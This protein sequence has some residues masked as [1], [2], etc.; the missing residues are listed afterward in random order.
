MKHQKK[1]SNHLTPIILVL[2]VVVV[3]L[4]AVLA[5]L[6]LR[7]G[8]EATV[9]ES[10][11]LPQLDVIPG[12]LTPEDAPLQEAPWEVPVDVPVEPEVE[13]VA[14]ETPYTTLYFPGEW[15]KVLLVEHLDGEVYTVKFSADL[16]SGLVVPLFEIRLGGAI[17]DGFACIMTPEGEMMAV[18]AE[19]YEFVPSDGMRDSEIII[20]YSMQEA[21]NDVLDRMNLIYTDVTGSEPVDN[22]EGQSGNGGTGSNANGAPGNMLPEDTGEAISFDTPGGTLKYPT[23]W[24]D[25]LHTET[26]ME[27]PYSVSF[28]CRVDGQEDLYLFTVYIGGEEGMLAGSITGDDGESRDVRLDIEELALEDWA[29]EEA[30]IARA[31]QE[32]LN[33]VLEKLG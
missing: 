31:M 20:V 30:Q 26:V 7:G 28:Y 24:S 22:K 33:F 5:I 17:R 21:M 12:E 4:I 14:I 32:D 10:A 18:S 1:N 9:N 29:E 6:M 16:E 11:Q 15:E 25:Y 3:A 23:R 19:V 13:P 8:D 2:A 27:E